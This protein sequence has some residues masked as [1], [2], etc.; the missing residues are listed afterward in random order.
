MVYGA[1]NNTRTSS[2]TDAPPYT[3]P[4]AW[5]EHIRIPGGWCMRLMTA[6]I[7]HPQL[8]PL[9]TLCRI[10][11]HGCMHTIVVPNRCLIA[12]LVHGA[13]ELM[14]WNEYFNQSSHYSSDKI[15]NE[16]TF[17][18]R[19]SNIGMREHVPGKARG[20]HGNTTSPWHP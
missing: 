6:P 11:V 3:V 19:G 9:H 14:T 20:H 8:M 17:M 2:E 5:P 4:T 18:H 7:Q 1:E 15:C 16:G 13:H 10:M 12:S